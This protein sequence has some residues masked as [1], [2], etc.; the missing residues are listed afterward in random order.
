MRARIV[1][2]PRGARVTEEV[3]KP[4]EHGDA[5]AAPQSE[6]GGVRRQLVREPA[7]VVEALMK[8]LSDDLSHGGGILAVRQEVRGDPRR[9]RGR[10]SVQPNPLL[11]PKGTL[12]EPHVGTPGLAANW[13]RKVVAVCR[14]IAES[15]QARSGPVGH[16]P[17]I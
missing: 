5:V 14:E 12:M 15:V 13:E 8:S 6:V 17:L 1:D 4:P 7:C 11:L 9:A 10:Q 2:V 3:E 16:D